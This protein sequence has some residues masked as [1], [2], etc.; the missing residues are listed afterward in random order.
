MRE[1]FNLEQIFILLDE[2]KKDNPYPQDIF[3]SKFGNFGRQVWDNC[4][5][6]IKKRLSE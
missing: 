5:D 3:K 1:N 6:E 2:V 4:I